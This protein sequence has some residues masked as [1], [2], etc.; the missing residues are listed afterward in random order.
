M[1]TQY[2]K[3][4]EEEIDNITTT[5]LNYIEIESVKE[6]RILKKVSTKLVT[7]KN[8]EIFLGK[9]IFIETKYLKEVI[10]RGEK[11]T[12]DLKEAIESNE[13]HRQEQQDFIQKLKVEQIGAQLE[14]K[15][16]LKQKEDIDIKINIRNK[17][18]SKYLIEIE[19]R[20]RSIQQLTLR[21]K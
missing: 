15:N 14:S 11:Y 17:L 19:S 8:K 2:I 1:T 9:E 5:V 16:L 12:P 4:K 3:S 21:K 10:E 18:R 6:Y 13:K 20:K 7:Q